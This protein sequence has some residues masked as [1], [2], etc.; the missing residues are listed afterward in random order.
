MGKRLTP[1]EFQARIREQFPSLKCS[2]YKGALKLIKCVCPKHGEF[3]IQASELL[4][5]N[6]PCYKCSLDARKE[7]DR[8]KNAA[9]FFKHCR[10][11]YDYSLVRYTNSATSVKIICPTHGVFEQSPAAHLRGQ[12]CP[13]CAKCKSTKSRRTNFQEFVD[14]A[15]KVHGKYEYIKS[16]YVGTKEYL[17]IKCPEHG[18]FRQRG[19]NHLAGTG[20]PVCGTVSTM[21]N[22]VITVQSTSKIERAVAK[23]LRSMAPV[24]TKH[25][26]N[27]GKEIDILLPKQKVGVEING[28]YW[29][30]KKNASYHQSKTLLA[31]AEGIQLF[32]M[33][34]H[35]LY[36][37]APIVKSMLRVRLGFAKVR[38]FA[39][40]TTVRLLH[41][42]EEKEFFES[43]HIQG[44][45]PSN[46]SY[47]LFLD[48]A[49]VMGMSFG[50]PRFN[51]QADWEIIRMSSKL[52]HIV[53]G[54]AA[55]LF[56][57]FVREQHPDMVITYADLDYGTGKVYQAIGFDFS[58]YA[59]PNYFWT[60]KTVAL[61]R[62]QTQKHKLSKLLGDKFSANLS[63]RENMEN[64]GYRKI[65]N[66]GNAVYTW[67]KNE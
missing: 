35:W 1:L 32:H 56:A 62:Y 11:P 5:K 13:S 24:E 67:R 57:A 49:L 38:V 6:V 43:T 44:Y 55:K 39:R 34:E 26:L 60:K 12:G 61:P 2:E 9:N 30:S 45:I 63:E 25:I 18:T 52:N 27:D 36:S 19:H 50:K 29:H 31:A 33:W 46:I 64:A 22:R 40:Q 4:R 48:E 53:V 8:E 54:G 59:K 65:F 10:E 16:S 28:L 17:T 66:S 15:Q 23:W 42:S 41:K 3:S 14:K 47:G 51:K 7:R 20:C 58:H 21:K 37:K